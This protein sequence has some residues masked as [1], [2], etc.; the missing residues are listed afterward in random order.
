MSRVDYQELYKTIEVIS[1]K[2]AFLLDD[3][4]IERNLYCLFML[5]D[6]VQH[7]DQQGINGK[8]TICISK[9]INHLITSYSAALKNN[10]VECDRQHSLSLL[11]LQAF[12]HNLPQTEQLA[13]V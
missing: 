10:W 11:C 1:D 8:Q 3:Y 13:A 7:L 2:S 5:R 9:A 4:S 12:Q 6:S